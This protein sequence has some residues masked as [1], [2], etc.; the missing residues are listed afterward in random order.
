[1]EVCTGGNKNNDGVIAGLI[2][3]LILC[4]EQEKTRFNLMLMNSYGTL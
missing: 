2:D 4:P 3:L 1:M